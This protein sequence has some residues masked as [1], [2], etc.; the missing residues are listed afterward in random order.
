MNLDYSL[1]SNLRITKKKTKNINYFK[2]F[3]YD[4]LLLNFKINISVFYSS[5]M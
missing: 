4:S 1:N 2:F 5:V 3:I